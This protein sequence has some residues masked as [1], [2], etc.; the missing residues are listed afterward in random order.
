VFHAQQ[1]ILERADAEYREGVAEIEPQLRLAAAAADS[2][3]R[4]RHPELSIPALR[5]AAPEPVSDTERGEAAR[6]N[7]VPEWMG[8]LK[9]ANARFREQIEARRGL[10][11]PAEHPDYEPLGEAF[12]G[13]AQ[14]TSGAVLQPPAAQMPPAPAL[15]DP[16]AGV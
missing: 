4:R 6:G 11:V 15:A 12:P 5:S 1:E 2:L 3:L 16:E 14:R 7:R 10:M 8:T 13:R 9:D